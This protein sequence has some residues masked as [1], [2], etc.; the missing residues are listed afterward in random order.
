M[1]WNY[2]RTACDDPAPPPAR[3][4]QTG[5]SLRVRNS[6]T[7]V[8]LLELDRRPDLSWQ[9]SWAGWDRSDDPP[10]RVLTVHHP[11]AAPQSL[12]RASGATRSRHF[13][14]D[15]DPAGDHLR[16]DSWTQGTTE[17]GSSGAPLFDAEGRVRGWLRGGHAA[18][19]N[20]LPD[21]YGRLAD[22][23]DDPRGAGYRLRDWLD[24]TGTEMIAV[25]AL[26]SASGS[27]D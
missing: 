8:A 3:Q 22:V 6:Q 24:P 27:T 26:A 25:D 20:H 16:V 17:G 12:A 23:W 10:G 11:D 4:F 5:A 7:D 19:D 9:V 15:D 21:W 18:C 1:L 13:S 14:Y 2:R